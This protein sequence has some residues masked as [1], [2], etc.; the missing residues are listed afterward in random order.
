[1]AAA[2]DLL[3]S[4]PGRHVA[5]LGEMLELGDASAEAHRAVGA[6]VA[7]TADLLVAIGPT[8][9]DYADGALA[10]GMPAAAIRTRRRPRRGG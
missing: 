3:A 8:A 1:M 9:T 6:H 5:V 4:L 7:H 10:A 2:L